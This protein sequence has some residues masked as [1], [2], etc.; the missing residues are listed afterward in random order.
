MIELI[1]CKTA[2]Y[3][4]LS[5]DNGFLVEFGSIQTKKIM[6]EKYCSNN[7][8]NNTKNTNEFNYKI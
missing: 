4:R 2:I 1:L 7:N 6:L 5:L 3:C 8:F